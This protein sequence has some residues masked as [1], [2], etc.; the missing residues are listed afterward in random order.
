MSKDCYNYA[1]TLA[2]KFD[3]H[4]PDLGEII[5][6]AAW[7]TRK[8]DQELSSDWRWVDADPDIGVLVLVGPAPDK[9]HHCGIVVSLLN[10]DRLPVVEHKLRG[11]VYAH[12]LDALARMGYA[13]VRY[14]SY[15]GES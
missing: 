4:Y 10:G 6:D 14:L 7:C 8:A 9:L 13:H 5:S 3:I 12:T 11:Q 1:R 15:R 2:Q